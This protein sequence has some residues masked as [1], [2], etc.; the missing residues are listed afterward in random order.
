M[1][2]S[3][4]R[5]SDSSVGV[6]DA[7]GAAPQGSINRCAVEDAALWPGYCAAA[8]L[9]RGPMLR[10][11]KSTIVARVPLA[12]ALAAIRA[13]ITEQLFPGLRRLSPPYLTQPIVVPM[14]LLHGPSVRILCPLGVIP[15]AF[16]KGIIARRR[17]FHVGL[18]ARHLP[19]AGTRWMRN[20]A[21]FLRRCRRL[22]RPPACRR[23][24]GS[25]IF[26]RRVEHGNHV[27]PA[28]VPLP[29]RRGP[30][31]ASR[32]RPFVTHLAVCSTGIHGR[33]AAAVRA[34]SVRV[35]G[36]TIVM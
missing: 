29:P 22:R 21:P 27:P 18:S 4:R 11:L 14:L 1:L 5:E 3:H 15:T 24:M 13:Q 20:G 12:R 17:L 34:R 25:R 32:T 23:A 26:T 9:G 33:Q 8:A 30:A 10:S 6:A 7:V 16:T 31:P 19:S 35:N 28:A 2:P 36:L